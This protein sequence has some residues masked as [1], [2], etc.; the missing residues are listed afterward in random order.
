MPK[1]NKNQYTLLEV[2]KHYKKSTE[3]PVD[4]KTHKAILEAWGDTVVEFLVDGR[5]V[6]LYKG[7]SKIGV[8]KRVR[9]NYV[10]FRASK[11]AGRRIIKSNAHSDFY[12]GY[13]Y[14][15]THK[16]KIFVKGWAL[17][18]SAHLAGLIG[19]V[20]KTHKGHTKFVQVATAHNQQAKAEFNRKI[21]KL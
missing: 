10:D 12:V 17:R 14:W 2:Y 3:E 11:L 4:Y 13:L 8:R 18:T 15:N 19:D 1:V 7:L 6:P 20:F 21:H 9:I 5:D 16:T